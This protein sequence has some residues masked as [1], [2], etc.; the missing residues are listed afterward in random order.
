MNSKRIINKKKTLSEILG[1]KA[2]HLKIDGLVNIFN[3]NYIVVSSIWLIIFILSAMISTYLIIESFN[4]YYEYR[5]T[6]TVRYVTEESY[7]LPTI[8]FCNINPFTTKYALDLLIKANVG[9]YF[10]G[11]LAEG[12]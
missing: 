4:Q 10:P 2:R 1:E 5:V 3:S 6:S 8:T 11:I 7:V 9:S 12:R